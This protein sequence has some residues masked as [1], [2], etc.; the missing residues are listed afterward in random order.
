[1]ALR[2]IAARSG[3]VGILPFF[4]LNVSRADSVPEVTA[5]WKVRLS[6]P[7]SGLLSP[8]LREPCG[9]CQ[10]EALVGHGLPSS[11]PQGRPPMGGDFKI[12]F[13]GATEQLNAVIHRWIQ[14]ADG[15]WCM[16]QPMANI[17]ASPPLSRTDCD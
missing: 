6:P 4:A 2:S 8:A 17:E 14:G 12:D 13:Q 10:G 16:N 15:R 1:V 7:V 3:H 9:P 5:A 11:C